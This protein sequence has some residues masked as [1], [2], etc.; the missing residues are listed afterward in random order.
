MRKMR[1]RILILGASGMLGSTLIR[2]FYECQ[3]CDVIGTVRDIAPSMELRHQCQAEIVPGVDASNLKVLESVILSHQPTV[4]INC[5]GIVKQVDESYDPLV[6]VPINSLLPHYLAQICLSH[7]ARLIHISTDC[8]FSG[9]KGMY[10]EKDTPDATDLYGMS[11]RIGEVDAEGSITLRTSIVGHE[12]S[13][14]RS[15]VDWFLSQDNFVNGFTQAIFSGLPTVELAR[16]IKDFVIPIED[17]T[18]LFNVSSD[19]IS[20]YELLRMVAS[21]YGKNIDIQEDDS[22]KIDRSLDST[23]FRNAT[24]YQPPHWRD[25]VASMHSFRQQQ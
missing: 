20:K 3:D 14:S 16:I 4:V 10:I 21:V 2:Y 1:N 23:K 5:I 6:A 12:V 13:T 15:L 7:G 11:K 17:L 19:P 9:K 8:V 22:L 25:L 24:G 18:G